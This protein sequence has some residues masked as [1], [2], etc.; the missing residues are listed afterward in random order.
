MS[1]HFTQK[2]SLNTF[3]AALYCRFLLTG[4]SDSVD[5]SVLNQKH[6]LT[7]GCKAAF[8]IHIFIQMTCISIYR[9]KEITKPSPSQIAP[10]FMPV[11]CFKQ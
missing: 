7:P 10:F 3:F 5:K 1:L 8:H 6:R 11:S 4:F 2:V 9:H